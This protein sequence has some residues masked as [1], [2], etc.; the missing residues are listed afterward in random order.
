MTIRTRASWTTAAFTAAVLCG[1]GSG[2]D[3]APGM[4]DNIDMTK[5]SNSMPGNTMKTI[6]K[7]AKAKK[8]KQ[9]D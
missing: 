7:P 3:L 4:P 1:C 6:G 5:I 2:G 8:A 9:A